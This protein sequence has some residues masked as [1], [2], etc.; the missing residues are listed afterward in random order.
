MAEQRQPDARTVVQETTGKAMKRRGL[1]AAAL[2]AGMVAKQTSGPVAAVGGT[3]GTPLIIGGSFPPNKATEPTALV[4]IP[5]PRGYRFSSGDAFVA[6]AG[7]GGKGVKGFTNTGIGIYGSAGGVG[8]KGVATAGTGVM[9]TSSG[10]SLSKG[11]HGQHSA[12]G[13]AVYGEA[14]A[15]GG[16]GVTG[17]SG[18]QFGVLGQST[19]GTGVQGQITGA[20]ATNTRAVV[21]LNSSTGANGIGGYG[22]VGTAATPSSIG[23]GGMA[24]AD[25]SSAFSGGT[26]NPNAYAGYFQGQVVVAGSFD[27]SPLGNKH[28]V[29]PHP[30]GTH[31]TFYSVESPECWVEDF[32][33]GTL[34]GGKAEVALD[35]D[36]AALTHTD[37]YH[38]FIT[39]HDTHHHLSVAKRA[40]GGFSVTADVD[41]AK[42]KGKQAADL[43]G[44]FSYRVVARPKTT[45]KVERLAK[46]TLPNLPLPPLP[47]T[48]PPKQP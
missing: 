37:Q 20:S 2:V 35:A 17:V 33:T 11:V 46:A 4:I 24:Y 21:G 42:L 23:I 6:V 16:Y 25:G 31:R 19:S 26:S 36:F 38:V 1:M 5:S 48:E 9:G 41:G 10:D 43:S 3:N 34:A 14:T 45:A 15:A 28:G 44:T 39:E 40:A 27:V 7:D 32:G 8:V 18:N 12:S 13:Y 22:V 47:K 29:A 30:D